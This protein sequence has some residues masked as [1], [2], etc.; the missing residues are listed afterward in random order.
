MSEFVYNDIYGNESA[1]QRYQ[2]D[3]RYAYYNTVLK[4]HNRFFQ[5]DH[6]HQEIFNPPKHTERRTSRPLRSG[7]PYDYYSLEKINNLTFRISRNR[8]VPPLQAHNLEVRTPRE[9]T[10]GTSIIKDA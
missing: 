10:R 1:S 6:L 9:G 2:A 3:S 7:T 8:Q 4:M 5:N